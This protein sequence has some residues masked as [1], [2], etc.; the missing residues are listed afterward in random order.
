VLI[1]YT[2]I[3]AF[4]PLS[5]FYLSIWL[6]LQLLTYLL[7]NKMPIRVIHFRANISSK[8]PVISHPNPIACVVQC[9]KQHYTMK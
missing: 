2:D 8:N 6:Q 7:M 1:L 9:P 5:V 4:V 3:V